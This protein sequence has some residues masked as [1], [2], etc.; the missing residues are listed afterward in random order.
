MTNTTHSERL[1]TTVLIVDDEEMVRMAMS[2]ALSHAG[3]I[4]LDVANGTEALDLYQRHAERINVIML[5][6]VL[7]DIWGD[8]ILPQ[9]QA[10]NP[11]VKVIVCSGYDIKD[12]EFE[13]VE[14]ILKKPVPAEALVHTVRTAVGDPT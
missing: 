5:D 6:L 3:Y 13:G 8:D 14:T 9:L 7:P 11:D 12:G 2:T 4:V 1:G 10:I